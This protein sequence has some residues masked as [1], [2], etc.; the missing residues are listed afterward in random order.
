MIL[1]NLV[2]KIFLIRKMIKCDK[3]KKNKMKILKNVQFKFNL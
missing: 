1:L 3:K 2:I